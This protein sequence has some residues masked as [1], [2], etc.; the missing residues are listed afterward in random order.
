MPNAIYELQEWESWEIPGED[1]RPSRI[2]IT[3]DTGLPFSRDDLLQVRIGAEGLEFH[4]K[5]AEV[6]L[7]LTPSPAQQLTALFLESVKYF[8]PIVLTE[9]DFPNNVQRT[10]LA[11]P[12][13]GPD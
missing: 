2:R 11:A 5:D 10:W 7:I 1:G 3:T 4:A 13:A 12:R 8:L 9:V 6:L